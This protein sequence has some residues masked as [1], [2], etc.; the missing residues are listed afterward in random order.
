MPY[1]VEVFPAFSIKSQ[2]GRK[3]CF[4]PVQAMGASKFVVEMMED[5]EEDQVSWE[6][7]G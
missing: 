6:A 5:V 1:T 2:T 4:E 7:I 3:Q